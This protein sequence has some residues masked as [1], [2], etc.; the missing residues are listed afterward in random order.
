M[1]ELEAELVL[2]IVKEL[3]GGRT[4]TVYPFWFVEHLQMGLFHAESLNILIGNSK[5]VKRSL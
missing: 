1:W 5:C 2:I 3:E 4:S